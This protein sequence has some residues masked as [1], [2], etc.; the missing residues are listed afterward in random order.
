MYQCGIKNSI[1]RFDND[2]DSSYTYQGPLNKH[3]KI[4]NFTMSVWMIFVTRLR[5]QVN[6]EKSKGTCYHIYD[7]LCSVSQYKGRCGK[8]ICPEFRHHQYY[9]CN[10]RY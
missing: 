4:L 3:G 1:N 2:G 9:A 10:E 5:G 6:A 7:A 8:K